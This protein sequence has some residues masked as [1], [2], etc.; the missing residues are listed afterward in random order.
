MP[1]TFNPDNHSQPNYPICKL[2]HSEPEDYFH[3]IAKCPALSH[4]RSRL[5][6]SIPAEVAPHLPD[7]DPDPVRFMLDLE[8]INPLKLSPPTS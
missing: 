7:L 3:F 8:W 2:C 1:A 4:V 6:S 5:L